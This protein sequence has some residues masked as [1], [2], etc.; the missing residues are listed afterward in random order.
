MKKFRYLLLSILLLCICIIPKAQIVHAASSLV[1]GQ[2]Y[3]YT[4][5]F[6]G[7]NE[8][9][10]YD[11]RIGSYVGECVNPDLS[12]AYGNMER[13]AKVRKL[14]NTT[15]TAK[16]AYY[17]GVQKGWRNGNHLTDD[18]ETQIYMLRLIQ[19]TYHP[20][21]TASH[22]TASETTRVR[23]GIQEA[24]SVTVPSTF[25]IYECD[26][27]N[28]MQPFVVWRMNP[29]NAEKD[30]A[31]GSNG[32][33][34]AAVKV[35]DV[36]TYKIEWTDGDNVKIEDTLS[37][38]LAFE[39]TP[40]TGCTVSGQKM[41]CNMTSSSGSITYRVKV[42]D[43]AKAA[44][45]VCNSAKATSGDQTKNLTKLCNPVPSKDY[46]SSSANGKNH[47][48]VK[49]GDIITYSIKYAN[50]TS[51]SA[52]VVV[53]DTISK[54]L[55]Y[56]SGSGNFG[57]PTITANSDG[58]TKLVWNRTLAAGAVEELTYKVRVV[59]AATYKVC[60]G[61][62]VKIGNG[63]EVTLSA[64]CNPTPKKEYGGTGLSDNKG[65]NH[66]EVLPPDSKKG[67]VGD[68]I[69][70]KITLANVKTTA[71]TVV[72]KDT[73]S[74]GLTYNNDAT[75]TN[76]TI[77][78]S[79]TP[80]VNSDTKQTT[81]TWTISVEPGKT[82]VLNY[83]AKVN[84]DAINI[85]KNNATA[86]YQGDPTIKL[87]ELPNPVPRKQYDVDTAN[88]MNGKIVQKDDV[89][90]YNI[91]YANGFENN[92]TVNL[93]DTL[94]KGLTYTPGTAKVCDFNKENCKTLEEA[95]MAEKVTVLT[96][97]KTQILW[98]RTNMPSLG[99]EVIVYDV[100]VTG[101]TIK[102]NNDFDIK[103]CNEI[104]SPQTINIPD[105]Q[106]QLN[107]SC[108]PQCN[109][110]TDK[111]CKPATD[112][113]CTKTKQECSYTG[114]VCSNPWM[115][116]EEL[117]NPVPKK[118]YNENTPSGF[119][120][121]AVAKRDRIRYEIRYTNVE[122]QPVTIIIK[123][124]I[125]KGIEYV[126]GTSKINGEKI[127]DPKLSNNN[128][129][130]TWTRKD[131]GKDVEES[132]TYEVIVTGE[133]TEVINKACMTY[134]NNPDYERCLTRLK[135]P[136]P[137]KTYAK[138]TPAGANGAI[139]KKKDVIRYSIKYS[140]VKEQASNVIIM[141]NLSRGLEYVK[142]SAKVNGKKLDPVS[143]TKD[144]NGTMLVWMKEIAKGAKEELTYDVKVTGTK[145][146][147]EN[148]A[149]I[150]YDDDP[151]IK[152]DELRN[153]LLPP[154]QTV[155]VPNTASQV[156]IA[157]LVAGTALV[158]AGGYLIYRRYKNA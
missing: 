130:L 76:G 6:N 136:V 18:F 17:Y 97:G 117:K 7:T 122:E 43:A 41:T 31:T 144:A 104:L 72:V 26:P 87:K 95:G 56:V 105:C 52:A 40:P 15:T 49:K 119:D 133:T 137:R 101:E 91:G 84:E 103:T 11:F 22:M 115:D 57:N 80:V 63:S 124:T 21:E 157:G 102:V 3:T 55:E 38:G 111:N 46:S 81:V 109:P 83:S 132:L 107:P 75:V 152:L 10:W 5:P 121:S 142:G 64:L 14:S 68:D 85:V 147:V 36:I 59:E 67:R 145:K 61:A 128:K 139:V 79:P 88:G 150:Q 9:G 19:Y 113:E 25:E 66:H 48:S 13:E 23:N 29:F 94:S 118:Q 125:S 154:T 24:S 99:I 138:N 93:R 140:N 131:V 143:V 112:S 123:D 110:S 60:N 12:A 89:I 54:G 45:K 135:N 62:K 82:A 77:T 51:S 35:G 151:T 96:N 108:A 27:T 37:A 86:T 30:Y 71:Q 153:P 149:T 74:K 106:E 2:T 28:D 156:A 134:S 129:T 90:T 120:Q 141:D 42:L 65:W 92:A 126:R 39:G 100:T 47:A 53:T 44:G 4:N 146:L 32:T 116:I 127:A 73:L 1:D 16:V 98:T 158:G 148:N 114:L 58:S 8:R 69:K 78:A 34:N 155:R 33:G 50:T 70:Y 20:D